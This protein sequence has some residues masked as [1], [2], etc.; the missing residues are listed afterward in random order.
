MDECISTIK[1]LSNNES[2]RNEY[3]E[4]AY[5]CYSWYD[6]KYV[7]GDMFKIIDQQ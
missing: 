3:R 7:F 2:M 1:E 5:K 4:L 6:S